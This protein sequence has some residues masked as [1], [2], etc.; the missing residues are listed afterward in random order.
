MLLQ[1]HEHILSKLGMY[2]NNFF[3]ESLSTIRGI[4]NTEKPV[5]PTVK[6]REIHWISRDC[7][8]IIFNSL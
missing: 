7:H 1:Q 2:M 3:T 5:P 8:F 4:P 6:D